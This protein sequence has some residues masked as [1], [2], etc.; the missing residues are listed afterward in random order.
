MPARPRPVTLSL[1]SCPSPGGEVAPPRRVP[2]PAPE[3]SQPSLQMAGCPDQLTGPSS[4]TD[5]LRKGG[6]PLHQ[7]AWGR[8]GQMSEGTLSLPR[9]PPTPQPGRLTGCWV[10][11][12]GKQKQ[13]LHV[14]YLTPGPDFLSSASPGSCTSAWPATPHATSTSPTWRTPGPSCPWKCYKVSRP[15]R[16]GW[17]LP[18][19]SAG[20]RPP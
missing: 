8:P 12:Q 17:V 11:G 10:V 5:G 7:P 14:L 15:P 4:C 3:G 2:P 9:T 19:L 18:D 6:S 20:A 13:C 1:P 16:P